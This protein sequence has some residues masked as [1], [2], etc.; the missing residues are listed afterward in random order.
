LVAAGALFLAGAVPVLVSESGQ[1]WGNQNQRRNNQ[2]TGPQPVEGATYAEGTRST[3]GYTIYEVSGGSITFGPIYN[4][5]GSIAAAEETVGLIGSDW[6]VRNEDGDGGGF[7]IDDIAGPGYTVYVAQASNGAIWLYEEGLS[8]LVSVENPGGNRSGPISAAYGNFLRWEPPTVTAAAQE[9][10]P[11]TPVGPPSGST[12]PDPAF[13]VPQT[14]P[15]LRPSWPPEVPKLLPFVPVPL[16]AS[17]DPAKAPT[18]TPQPAPGAPEPEP[19]PQPAPIQPGPYRP[20]LPEVLE[21]VKQD[22]RLTPLPFP[23]RPRSPQDREVPTAEEQRQTNAKR[24]TTPA[25]PVTRPDARRYGSRNVTGGAPRVDPQ[26]V[27]EELGRVEQK[28]GILLQGMDTTPDWL[29]AL[30]G[31]LIGDLLAA[32]LDALVVDVPAT[33]YGFTAPCDKDEN[34]DPVEW[35]ADIA[36]A[37]YQPA[38]VAR[39]DAIAEALGVLKGWRQPICRVTPPPSNVTVTAYEVGPEA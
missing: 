1:Q 30:A 5:D 32:L 4:Q 19:L 27:A 10:T 7:A 14:V 24:R 31:R 9:G 13:V 36:A 35:S 38:V 22:R 33:S 12:G 17:P 2:A 37:D 11:S 25:V 16:P 34:G 3:T 23:N 20:A 29:D 28:L 6:I 39:L 21:L 26:A 8:S 15:M 18:T